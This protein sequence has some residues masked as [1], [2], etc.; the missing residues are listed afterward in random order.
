MANVTSL[1]QRPLKT[2]DSLGEEL[3]FFVRAL[4]WTP[5]AIRRYKKEI[6][7]LL[8]EVTLGSGA[9][10]VIG[11]TVG[12]ITQKQIFT[13]N[14]VGIHRYETLNHIGTPAF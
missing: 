5:R 12:M 3:A 8:A 11:R 6:M 14:D 13:I 1:Y 2:I 4:A 10:A 7:R 9:L